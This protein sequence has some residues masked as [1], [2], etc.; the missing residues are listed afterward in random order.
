MY[1]ILY[2]YHTICISYYMY[3]ILYVSHTI[4]ISY[5]MY[6]ILYVYHTICISYYMYI[7]YISQIVYYTFRRTSSETIG[8]IVLNEKIKLCTYVVYK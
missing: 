4:C 8:I 6:I 3:I 1:I 7:I 2:V 5:Y